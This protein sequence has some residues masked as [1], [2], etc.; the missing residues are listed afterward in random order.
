MP[1]PKFFSPT[2][3][4]V[5]RFAAGPQGFSIVGGYHVWGVKRV[6][7][8]ESLTPLLLRVRTATDLGGN[9]TFS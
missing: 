3:V 9:K 1:P 2:E 7:I 8:L 4:G 5:L 6:S